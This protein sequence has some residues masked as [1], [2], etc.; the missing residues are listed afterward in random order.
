MELEGALA[1]ALANS[2]GT[3][4]VGEVKGGRVSVSEAVVEE[5]GG[6]DSEMEARAGEDCDVVV[7][8]SSV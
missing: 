4:A 6:R 8:V 3:E 5:T 1:A 7:I 2:A